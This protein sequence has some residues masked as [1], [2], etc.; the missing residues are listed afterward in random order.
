MVFVLPTLKVVC[1]KLLLMDIDMAGLLD[2]VEL[3][4]ICINTQSVAI[5]DFLLGSEISGTLVS[6]FAVL[7]LMCWFWA[8]NQAGVLSNRT[9]LRLGEEGLLGP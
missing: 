2:E 6:W 9:L 1:G 5:L 4:C 8:A 3:S 7:G